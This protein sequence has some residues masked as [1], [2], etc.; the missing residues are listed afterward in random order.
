MS[1]TTDEVWAEGTMV[2][3]LMGSAGA[4]WRILVSFLP[5]PSL[6]HKC[7]FCWDPWIEG[8]NILLKG[9]FFAVYF[10]L[11]PE[12]ESSPWEARL[13]FPVSPDRETNPRFTVQ[14]LPPT[15]KTTARYTQH[16]EGLQGGLRAISGCSDG[17][18][19][20]CEF[21]PATPV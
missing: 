12:S 5:L 1:V 19:V 13:L 4:S 17:A 16:R 21:P 14:I 6:V 9:F 18:G 11:L 20:N 10:I 15:V 3:A 7:L 2:T 8:C